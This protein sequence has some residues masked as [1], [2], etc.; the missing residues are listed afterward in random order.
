METTQ[1]KSIS[2]SLSA[3]VTVF[4]MAIIILLLIILYR[5]PSLTG[6]SGLFSFNS[7]SSSKQKID[8]LQ[9]LVNIQEH[10]SYTVDSVHIFQHMPKADLS[11]FSKMSANLD[12]LSTQLNENKAPRFQ[13]YQNKLGSLPEK[14]KSQFEQ[15]QAKRTKMSRLYAS[16]QSMR[17]LIP[18]L[19]A[20]NDE[21]VIQLLESQAGS[22]MI[23]LATRQMLLLQR[24]NSN[25]G[26][27]VETDSELMETAADR[28]GRDTALMLQFY[29][30]MYNGSEKLNITKIKDK[31]AVEKISN[32][33]KYSAEVKRH[34]GEMLALAPDLFRARSIVH[35]F[36]ADNKKLVKIVSTILKSELAGMN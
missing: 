20:L 15:L 30:N 26:V 32:I 16:A 9:L 33:L 36:N 4:G 22:N 21:L 12:R 25:I 13:E 28:F 11:A 3:L 10:S 31:A 19:L 8:F 27:F 34:I 6:T 17:Q 7:S 35:D 18:E 1:N 29:G 5:Q 14:I 2:G 23:Y 24:I